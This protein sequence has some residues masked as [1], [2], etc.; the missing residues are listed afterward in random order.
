MKVRVPLK[1]AGSFGRAI[2]AISATALL[3]VLIAALTLSPMEAGA[4]PEGVDKLYHV[5]AFASLAFPISIVRPRWA[6]WVGLGVIAYGGAIEIVQPAFGRE[7]EWV[8]FVADGI[9]AIIG[10]TS[11]YF[12]SGRFRALSRRSGG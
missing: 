8:D 10:A 6:L 4:G 5:L 1:H 11:G 12:L 2:S 3:G 7:A 9:G